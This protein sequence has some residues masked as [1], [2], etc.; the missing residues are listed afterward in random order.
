MIIDKFIRRATLKYANSD[1]Q[2]FIKTELLSA[3]DK[4]LDKSLRR[5]VLPEKHKEVK[6]T[7]EAFLQMDEFQNLNISTYCEALDHYIESMDSSGLEEV[8]SRVLVSIKQ[9]V[10]DTIK[11]I[12]KPI[13]SRFSETFGDYF[14]IEDFTNHIVHLM[15]KQ[16]EAE[17]AAQKT[18]KDQAFRELQNE[19]QKYHNEHS[20]GALQIHRRKSK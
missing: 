13:L 10:V 11:E 3:V 5:H 19:R 20:Y 17:Q 2:T 14:D 4:A 7:F 15:N 1:K 9:A 6:E 8:K 12:D 16:K 18:I